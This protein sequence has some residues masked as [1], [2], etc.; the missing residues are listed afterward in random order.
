[1]ESWFAQEEWRVRMAWGR[2][3]AQRAGRKGDILVV[4]DV[5]CFSTSAV[6]AVQHGGVVLPCCNS[7]E[8]EIASALSGGVVAVRREEAPEKG[9][10]SLSPL[11]Y[12]GLEPGTRICLPSPNG[13]ACCGF[14]DPNTPLLIGSLVNAEATADAIS[15]LLEGSD[16]NVTILACGERWEHA[17][18]D[19]DIRFAIEDYLGAGAIIAALDSPKSPEVLVCEAAFTGSQPCL[20][21]ILWNCGSGIELRE[22]GYEADVHHAAQLDLYTAVPHRVG[23]ALKLWTHPESIV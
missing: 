3:G 12:L 22:R 21:D 6:T 14:A 2:A 19:G 15:C 17:S 16:R 20:S 11:T 18:A 5:L 9:R 23:N 13:A 4:V 7:E 10:F 1:M 8:A